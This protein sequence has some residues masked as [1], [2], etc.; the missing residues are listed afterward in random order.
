[1]VTD[2]PYNVDYEGSTADKLRIENDNL[3]EPEFLK[4]L[5]AAFDNMVRSLKPGGA[6]YIWH[7]SRVQAIFE[8]ALSACGLTVRQQLIWNKNAFTLGRQDYQWKHEP[9]LYGWKDG[10][11]HFFVSDR[12]LPTV[13]DYDKPM[14]NALH[15]TMKPIPL[16]AYQVGN[17]SL[18]GDTVLDLFGG[19]GTTLMACEKLDRRCMMMEFDPRY[20][21]V[22][23]N[24]W[25][26]MTGKKAVR[27][28]GETND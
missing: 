8:Q 13:M 28:Q 16:I 22:I 18:R 1:M 2:P 23:V 5:T 25:E 9:C 7:A 6:F 19:S 11:A 27:I 17:S 21:D 20:C 3:S 4:F 24:R 12:S 14:R 15:P 26:N 10:A